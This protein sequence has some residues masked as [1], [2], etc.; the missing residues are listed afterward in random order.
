MGKRMPCQLLAVTPE[1]GKSAAVNSV[2]SLADAIQD[3]NLETG[4]MWG[5]DALAIIRGMK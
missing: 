5:D 4:F 3:L 2:V 1:G